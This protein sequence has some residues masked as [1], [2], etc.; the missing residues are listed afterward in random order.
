[1]NLD[2]LQPFFLYKVYKS[3]YKILALFLLSQPILRVGDVIN[4]S[5]DEQNVYIYFHH[6]PSQANYL[7][8]NELQDQ[9]KRLN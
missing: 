4:F 7:L 8:I 1:M 9:F 6:E 3:Y 2:N 5:Y